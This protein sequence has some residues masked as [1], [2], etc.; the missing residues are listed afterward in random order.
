MRLNRAYNRQQALCK[1]P[2]L[3]RSRFELVEQ[4]KAKYGICDENVYN[5]DEASFMMGKVMIQLVVTGSERR[6][7]PKA[8]QPGNCK[9]ATVIQGI[10]AVGWNILLLIIFAGKHHLSAWYEEDIPCNWAI[11][12]SNNSC[13]RVR[14]FDPALPIVRT[15]A[16]SGPLALRYGPLGSELRMVVTKKV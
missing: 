4:T 3:T 5:C 6:G 13:V 10:N 14:W 7:Q 2:V 9:W 1:D 16:T 11:A 12:V 8:V 15:T